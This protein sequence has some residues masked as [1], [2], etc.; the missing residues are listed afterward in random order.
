MA[1]DIIVHLRIAVLKREKFVDDKTIWL[2]S[3]GGA[4]ISAAAAMDLDLDFQL[5]FCIRMGAE[6]IRQHALGP[7]GKMT[8]YIGPHVKRSLPKDAHLSAQGKLLISVTETP[9]STKVYGNRLVGNFKSRQHIYNM[10]MASTYIPL[11]YETPVR[12]GIGVFYWDGGFS[13]N[14]PVLKDE[15]T[16]RVITTTVSP[17]A[18]IAD[19]CP[20]TQKTCNIEHLIPCNEE[21]AM[22]IYERGRRDAMK[23]VERIRK[24]NNIIVDPVS[25]AAG[26]RR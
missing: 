2:G 13:N 25:K 24:E 3:S 9:Q 5:R 17:V 21:E 12:P 1:T 19:I 16:G 4:L 10:L 22:D 14:Q 18:R 15:E 6:S 26:K 7:V 23:Y 11:Y 20:E 8:H